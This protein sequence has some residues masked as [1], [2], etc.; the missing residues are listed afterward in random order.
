MVKVKASTTQVAKKVCNM[1]IT[2]NRIIDCLQVE[3]H[4][5]ISIINISRRV[6]TPTDQAVLKSNQ[7]DH[8]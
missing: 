2:H 6:L 8:S 7:L 1:I 4:R 5:L 3:R